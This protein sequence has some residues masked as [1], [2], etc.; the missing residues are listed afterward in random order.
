MLTHYTA[1]LQNPTSASLD[2]RRKDLRSRVQKELRQMKNTWWLTK[3]REI[4]SYA[5]SN[6]SQKFYDAIKSTYGPTHHSLHPVR[7]KDGNTKIN[8]ESFSLG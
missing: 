2:Q 1:K 7:S 5:D 3:A 4:Q 6:D 8:K